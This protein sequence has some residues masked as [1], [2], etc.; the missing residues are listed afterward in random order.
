MAILLEISHGD[1]EEILKISRST[2]RGKL[3]R[4]PQLPEASPALA[5]NID[6]GVTMAGTAFKQ[7]LRTNCSGSIF[8]D[9]LIQIP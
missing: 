5:F 4:P 7:L 8:T 2:R 9:Y 3:P 6:V 1:N